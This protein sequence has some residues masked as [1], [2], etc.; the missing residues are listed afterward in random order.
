[1]SP[2]AVTAY[3]LL[4][5]VFVAALITA[6]VVASKILALGGIFVP[7]GVLA[8]SVTFPM[9]DTICEVWG[10]GRAQLVVNAG[11]LVQLLVWGLILL[12]IHLPAAPFWTQ[13]QAYAQVLGATGR[14]I[15]ASLVAYAVSQTLDVLVFGW[16]KERLAS[17][18]L[19]LRNNVSTLVS[20][21][22]DTTV[23]VTIAFAGKFD[24]LPLIGGQLLVKWLIAVADTP[25]VYLLVHL[26][27]QRLGPPREPAGAPA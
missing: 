1:M 19:W 15:A 24:L 25:V 8:Y 3:L 16:L 21:A 5:V 22:V 12:A 27:R 9:T 2:R 13:Q 14:I 26:V 11:F 18:R 17:R 10:R 4:A 23:F 20:Q 6:N 7:A